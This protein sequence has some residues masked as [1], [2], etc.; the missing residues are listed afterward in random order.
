M[1]V[2][3][4]HKDYVMC[5]YCVTNK[6][7]MSGRR[8]AALRLAAAFVARARAGEAR[9]AG[10]TL[11]ARERRHIQVFRLPTRM[12]GRGSF[13]SSHILPHIFRITSTMH[14]NYAKFCS[15]IVAQHILSYF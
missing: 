6:S 9:P 1:T 15:L 7:S 2:I 8:P 14:N 5:N 3:L 10:A 4:M 13:F 11:C 12:Q